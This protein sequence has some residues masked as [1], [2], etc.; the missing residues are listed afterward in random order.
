MARRLVSFFRLAAA[1][2]ATAFAAGTAFGQKPAAAPTYT[3]EIR[4]ILESR[5]V[6]CHNHEMLGNAATS[7]GLDLGS[8][9]ATRNGVNGRSVIATTSNAASSDL[10]V[11]LLAASPQKMM[12][13]GG[14][15]LPPDQ[16]EL[17]KKWIAAGA[18]EGAG[19]HIRTAAAVTAAPMPALLGS[20]PVVFTTQL[21]APAEILP[22]PAP[23]DLSISYQAKIGP[24]AP[25][26]SLAY[27]PDGLTLAVGGY[28]AVTLWSTKSGKP[29]GCITHLPGPVQALAYRPDGAQLAIAG[30]SPGASGDVRIIDTKT[31]QPVGAG[32]KGHTEVVLSVAWSPD[33]SHIATGSQ[34][35]TARIWE[36]PSGRELKSFKDHGDTVTA[37]CFSPDGKSLYTASMDHSL[38]RFD[39]DKGILTR[40]FTG[41]NDVVNGL[42]VSADGKRIVSSGTE[43]NLRWWN[44]ETGDIANNN[45]GHNGPVNS[46]VR[47]IDGKLAVSVS[48]DKTARVWDMNSTGQQRALEG[49]P[50]WLYTAAISPDS[51]FTAAGGADGVVRIWETANGKMR[52]MLQSWPPETGPMPEWLALTPEGYYDGSPAWCVLIKPT[53]SEVSAPAPQLTAWVKKLLLPDSVLKAWQGMPLDVAKYK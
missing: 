18:P 29:A 5:C 17:F 53:V 3:R 22:K 21:K 46:L 49:S 40:T 8:F 45:G 24:V 34:D 42:V 36:W 13:R 48:A 15:P 35:K 28:R 10:M 23:K 9:T 26:T 7:G 12:P 33:G 30:G 16:I 38:R 4:P 14:P 39:V 51:K 44:T 1:L 19:A 20:Q 37:V 43:P 25:I 2:L 31:M 47:S 52:L 32:L 11:R 50:D 27:S 41:H 6:V